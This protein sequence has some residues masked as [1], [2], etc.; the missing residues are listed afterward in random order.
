MNDPR[1]SSS[2]KARTFKR[3]LGQSL[4]RILADWYRFPIMTSRRKVFNLQTGYNWW[5]GGIRFDEFIFVL[6]N[7]DCFHWI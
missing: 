3:H 7:H 4:H 6:F 5:G 2:E 1:T